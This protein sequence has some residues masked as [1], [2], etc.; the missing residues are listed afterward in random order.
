M[1]NQKTKKV[2]ALTA[3]VLIGSFPLVAGDSFGAPPRLSRARTSGA[4]AP[5]GAFHTKID[6]GRAF[7]RFSRTDRHADIV[8]S[9][10][11]AHGRLVFWRGSSY[12]PYWEAGRV[13]YV[14]E[15]IPR[16]GDGAA[17][18]PDRVNTFSRVRII[19]SSPSRVIVHWRYDPEF[20]GDNPKIGVDACGF[21][22]E[23]FAITPD[24]KVT[25]TIR[26]GTDRID[27]WNDPLRKTVQT[28]TLTAAGIEHVRTKRPGAS[29]P[30]GMVEGNPM[31]A[32]ASG[33]PV[34][35]WPFDEA[36]GNVTEE[37]VWQR[38]SV[39]AGHKSLWKKGVSGTALQFD[40][41][42]SMVSL[43]AAQ[44]PIISGS[45]T[46]EGWVA[47]GAYPWHWAPLIQQGDDQGY[48]LGVDGHG[49]PGFK[50]QVAGE[51]HVLQLSGEPPHAGNMKLRRWYH[52]AGTYDRASGMM[53]LYIDGKPVAAKTVP[54]SGIEAADSPIQ[55]G[56]GKDRIPVDNYKKNATSYSFD[57]LIDEVRI[58]DSALG[59]GDVA[60]SFEAMRPNADLVEHPDMQSR[61]FPSEGTGG[62][63]EAKY[64][65]LSYHEAWD[66]VFRVGDHPDIVVGFDELPTRFVFWRG[67]STIPH[68]VND[69]NQWYTNEFN[70]TWANGGQEP[71]AD[72]LSFSNHVRI[73]EKSPA[74]VVVHWRY[75]LINTHQVIARHNP[76][77]GWGEWCDWYWT[78]Y[79]DGMAAKRMRCWHEF[80]GGHEWHTGWPTIPPGQ[81]PEDVIE[82][83]PFLTLID[84]DGRVFHHNWDRTKKIDFRGG[85]N[86]HLVH[87]KGRYDP[88]DISDNTG[89]NSHVGNA[90]V[91]PWF[92]DF[93]AWNHWPI[94]L[95][96]SVGRP[97]SFPDRAIHS[98][99]IRANPQTYA[100][101][102]G[103]A[104]WED[105]LM[106]EGMTDLDAGTLTRLARSWLK[107]PAITRVTGASRQGYE[108]AERAY[109][110]IA[111]GG[112]IRFELSASEGSP[113]HNPAFV[114]RDWGSPAPAANMRIN[115]VRIK[116]G[117]DFRQGVVIDTDGCYA[118]VIWLDFKATS[119]CR[120]EIE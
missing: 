14:P 19:E 98:S 74:R 88:V 95:S 27:D 50:I 101:E 109:L 80:K 106:L 62:R 56:K 1:A 64:M 29:P 91:Q 117:P 58:Y 3:I 59:A 105:R 86:I 53:S 8:V 5:F 39:I 42:Y 87:T 68:I 49:Y 116:P 108:R 92:S 83:E 20:E 38:S 69:R 73:I 36:Q 15:V 65:R 104:P 72:Q 78:I 24:G 11:A 60:K 25:R 76:D 67:M 54:Q 115:G 119:P 4:K 61:G 32:P 85:K 66:N 10:T 99:L 13:E 12:L 31:R 45:L 114:I 118:L 70:E 17:A 63:F 71:M 75:P 21:V 28:F 112:T 46:L 79:P 51:W 100:K 9:V 48:F 110:L 102:T 81:R 107:A 33:S 82:T 23:Y 111:T 52:L 90:G 41:Y 97:A 93:P 113:I 84:L 47:I 43:A 44:A 96:D 77:T 55:I 89:G 37:R 34:A 6:S 40:G 30:V 16:T 7:E 57:G 22:D 120:F 103:D 2:L 18:M 26:Q 35:W 94:S